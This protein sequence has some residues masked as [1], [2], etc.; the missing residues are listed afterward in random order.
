MT[1][2]ASQRA[3]FR[4][5]SQ[6]TIIGDQDVSLTQ[7]ALEFTRAHAAQEEM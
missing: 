6:R 1:L 3:E 4:R 2:N 7:Q 5:R